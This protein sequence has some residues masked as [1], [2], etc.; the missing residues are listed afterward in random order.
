MLHDTKND[1]GI[2][3][4]FQEIYETYVKVTLILL[5]TFCNMLYYKW[6]SLLFTVCFKPIL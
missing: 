2:R 3:N 5:R 4:F 6:F 1:D